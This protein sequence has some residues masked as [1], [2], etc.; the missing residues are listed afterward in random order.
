M[1]IPRVVWTPAEY[2]I[3]KWGFLGAPG[4]ESPRTLLLRREAKN[5]DERT[6]CGNQLVLSHWE[7]FR[8]IIWFIFCETGDE[9][10]DGCLKKIPAIISRK[11]FLSLA[12]FHAFYLKKKQKKGTCPEAFLTRFV[13]RSLN[14]QGFMWC[15]NL[16][17]SPF[18]I[19]SLKAFRQLYCNQEVK[20]AVG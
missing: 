19:T 5:Y 9:V 1:F 6:C 12:I 3:S 14:W 11:F 20:A 2:S 4:K 16:H 7:V 13:R 8:A 17:V 18:Y 15:I 10:Q